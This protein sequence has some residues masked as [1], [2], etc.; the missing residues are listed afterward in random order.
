LSSIQPAVLTVQEYFERAAAVYID[1][2][3]AGPSSGLGA[4]PSKAAYEDAGVLGT[5]APSIGS[6]EDALLLILGFLRALQRLQ[7][8]GPGGAE[9]SF[10]SPT[11]L[12][13]VGGKQIKGAVLRCFML[14]R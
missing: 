1:V 11:P 14:C 6:A 2:D 13:S 4:G 10:M 5:I 3:D 8:A 9:A 12:R 7:C